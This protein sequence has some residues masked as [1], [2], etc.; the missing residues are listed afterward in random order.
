MKIK[1]LLSLAIIVLS[2]PVEKV[3]PENSITQIEI[4]LDA[5]RSMRQKIN[6]VPKINIA[7]DA[8]IKLADELKLK[9]NI[10]V[11]LR[12]FGHKNKRCNNTI[13][14]IPIGRDS[15]EKIKSI[16]NILVLNK[17]GGEGAF[18]EFAEQI[19]SSQS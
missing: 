13:L 16:P 4:I 11:G 17:N 2:L 10:H 19:L 12:I 8:L 3:F 1:I 7:R 6:G 18:R 14:E 5:S 15:I 9:K